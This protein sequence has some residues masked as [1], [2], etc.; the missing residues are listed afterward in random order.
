MLTSGWKYGVHEGMG[1]GGV[2][3]QYPYRAHLII[4]TEVR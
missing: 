3:G 2:G 4:C 1:W